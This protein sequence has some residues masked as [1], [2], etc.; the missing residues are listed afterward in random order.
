MSQAEDNKNKMLRK[1][2][3]ERERINDLRLSDAFIVTKYG[4]KFRID[5]KEVNRN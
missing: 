2:E 3:L 4:S 5:A 1:I